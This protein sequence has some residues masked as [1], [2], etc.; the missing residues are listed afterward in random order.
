MVL[1]IRKWHPEKCEE[2]SVDKFIIKIP[3]PEH[4]EH[5]H[6]REDIKKEPR[7][8]SSKQSEI[9]DSEHGKESS[10]SYK[11]CRKEARKKAQL[12]SHVKLKDVNKK[13]IQRP[14]VVPSFFNE[15]LLSEEAMAI[16]RSSIKK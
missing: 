13:T 14:K 2:S 5:L 3:E 12:S 11:E 1:H 4:L 7:E 15:K 8:T 10:Y 9:S 6:E 16:L